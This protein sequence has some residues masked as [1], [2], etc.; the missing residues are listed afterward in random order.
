MEDA[1]APAT[2]RNGTHFPSPVGSHWIGDV[3][4]TGV[5]IGPSLAHILLKLG[6]SVRTQAVAVA[7]Q[8]G[9]V[10]G[11]ERARPRSASPW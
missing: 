3:H 7:Y 6:A 1:E 9:L 10:S 4:G 2:G 8:K 11:G 5:D